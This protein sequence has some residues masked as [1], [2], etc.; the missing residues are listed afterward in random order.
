M[1]HAGFRHQPYHDL[2]ISF[3]REGV[4]AG[5]ERLCPLEGVSSCKKT[6]PKRND[7]HLVLFWG[8]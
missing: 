8:L 5:P 7:Y 1:G 6:K 4:V 3:C 2:F